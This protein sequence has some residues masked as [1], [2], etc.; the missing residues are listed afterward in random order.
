MKIGEASFG[1][2]VLYTSVDEVPAAQRESLAKLKRHDFVTDYDPPDGLRLRGVKL[3]DTDFNGDGRNESVSVIELHSKSGGGRA[4]GM[5]NVSINDARKAKDT[6][7]QRGQDLD[8][9]FTG[10]HVLMGAID[11]DAIPDLAI[12]LQDG[13]V[14]IFKGQ[15]SE[16]TR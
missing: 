12:V 4:V 11:G 7:G 8:A 1:A 3:D 16:N 14:A 2:A 15:V 6:E 10:S 9:N 13:S 5:F